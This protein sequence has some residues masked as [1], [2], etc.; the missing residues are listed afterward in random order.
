MKSLIGRFL[1]VMLLGAAC[2]LVLNAESTVGMPIDDSKAA[3]IRG[4]ACDAK[5]TFDNNNPVYCEGGTC[6]HSKP[7]TEIYGDGG[8]SGAISKSC[9]TGAGCGTYTG[10]A[11]CAKPTTAVATGIAIVD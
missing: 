4:G 7:N 11:D 2:I 5:F 3:C 8:T 6:N 10:P 9:G 1:G